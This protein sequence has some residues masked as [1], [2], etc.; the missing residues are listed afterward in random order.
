VSLVGPTRMDYPSAL[1]AVRGAAAVLS[2]F[3][4]DVYET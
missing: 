2:A 1:A 4:E 3:V